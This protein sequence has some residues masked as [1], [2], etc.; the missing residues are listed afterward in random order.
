MTPQ[1]GRPGR[2]W[3][4]EDDRWLRASWGKYDLP[5]LAQALGRSPSS[6]TERARK[7][8]LERK[9]LTLQAFARRFDLAT[10]EVYWAIKKSGMKVD[11]VTRS[12]PRQILHHGKHLA[13]TQEQQE[14]LLLLIRT[15]PRGRLLRLDSK[16][17][18]KGMWGVG[19]KPKCCNE[20]ETAERPHHAKGYCK[21]CY[22]RVFKWMKARAKNPTRKPQEGTEPKSLMVTR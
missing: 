2:R 22:V 14:V 16:K 20:C 18:P 19:M 9:T 12:D 5:R 8:E 6:I 21:S 7:L 10:S 15:R 4:P 13:I 1:P 17:T 3:L 11:R